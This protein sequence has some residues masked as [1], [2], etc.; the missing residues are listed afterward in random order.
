MLWALVLRRGLFSSIMS[1]EYIT[2]AV[3]VLHLGRRMMDG[4]DVG[5][6]RDELKYEVSEPRRTHMQ[7]GLGIILQDV[8]FLQPK[9]R[10]TSPTAIP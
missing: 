2:I 4:W 10:T 9:P 3:D 7:A 6:D 1:R 8:Y 5:P